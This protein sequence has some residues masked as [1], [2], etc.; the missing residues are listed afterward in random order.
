MAR[1]STDAAR[2]LE[3][4][5]LREEEEGEAVERRAGEFCS[6]VWGEEKEAVCVESATDEC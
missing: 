1:E 5:L 2:N 3:E 4:L 6:F